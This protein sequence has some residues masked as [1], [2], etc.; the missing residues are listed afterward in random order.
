[1]PPSKVIVT[2]TC[3]PQGFVFIR[4][5]LLLR[6]GDY[7]KTSAEGEGGGSAGG[8][9]APGAG[10]GRGLYIYIYIYIYMYI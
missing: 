4:G 8:G 1:M 5:G 7:Y 6:G 2:N 9:G 10:Y 3:P